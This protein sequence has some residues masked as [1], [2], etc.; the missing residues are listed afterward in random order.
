MKPSVCPAGNRVAAAASGPSQGPPA[1]TISS[2]RSGQLDRVLAVGVRP[3]QP[4]VLAPD[5]DTQ[6][7]SRARCDLRR[8]DKTPRPPPS[9]A[10]GVHRR[11]GGARHDRREVGQQMYRSALHTYSARLTM[12]TMS[13]MQPPTP[14]RAGSVRTRLPVAPARPVRPTSPA[15]IRMDP[16]NTTKVAARQHARAPRGSADSRLSIVTDRRVEAATWPPTPRSPSVAVAGLSLMTWIPAASAAAARGDVVIGVAIA[17]SQSRRDAALR[18]RASS[19]RREGAS[20]SMPYPPPPSRTRMVALNTPA[21]RRIA[22]R[23]RPPYDAPADERAGTAATIPMASAPWQGGTGAS[24][25]RP[26]PRA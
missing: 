2:G 24:T 17:T 18:P 13:E 11:R 25:P 15:D 20:G 16:A 7:V 3:L 14:V 12:D 4:T 5:S 19:K 1:L 26:A 8:R 9:E 21:R 10:A 23:A 6:V 22:P